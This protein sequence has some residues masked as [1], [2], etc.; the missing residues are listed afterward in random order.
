MWF[1]GSGGRKRLI[2]EQVLRPV[3]PARN[4]LAHTG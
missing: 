2:L 3:P 1:D 4:L